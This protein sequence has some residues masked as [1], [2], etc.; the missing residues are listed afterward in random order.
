MEIPKNRRHDV[1]HKLNAPCLMVGFLSGRPL[2]RSAALVNPRTIARRVFKKIALGGQLSKFTSNFVSAIIL[3]GLHRE[4]STGEGGDEDGQRWDEGENSHSAWVKKEG[5]WGCR[6][7]EEKGWVERR[8]RLLEE[9]GPITSEFYTARH[10]PQSVA[11]TCRSLFPPLLLM[12][13]G[14]D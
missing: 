12:S 3:S 13:R 7:R 10:R 2:R 6:K 8:T 4:G 1:Y 11:G 9:E 5:M 14:K